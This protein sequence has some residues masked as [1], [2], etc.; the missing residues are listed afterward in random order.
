[1]KS[2]YTRGLSA[3]LLAASCA[4]ALAGEGA[5]TEKRAID[6]RIVRVKLD[7]AIDVK[8]R[9]GEPASLTIIGDKR[10][11]EKTSTTMNGDTLNI[12]TEMRG[13]QLH[14]TDLRAELVLPHL[15]E[16]SSEGVGSTEVSGFSGEDLDVLLDGAGAMKINCKYKMLSATLGGVG[17]LNIQGADSDG[18]DLNLRGAGFVTLSGHG[19]WMKANLGGLGGLD[20]QQ[21]QVDT[22]NLELSGLGNA[23][24]TA[25]QSASL[26]LS[27][28]GSVTVYGKPATRN[29]SVDG[30]GHVS[31]K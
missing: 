29:V 18:V 9:Q 7:G 2:I 10:W 16:L 11:V 1:M 17:S 30:L 19:K 22:V 27:G 23:T 21:F 28:L 24:I 12:D 26:N 3:L 4:A 25:R 5:V 31:W 13:M 8:L 15:R 14:R 20:S 6:A